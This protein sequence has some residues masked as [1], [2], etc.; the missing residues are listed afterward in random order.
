VC[1]SLLDPELSFEEAKRRHLAYINTPAKPIVTESATKS[2]LNLCDEYPCVVPFIP[3]PQVIEKLIM[4]AVQLS[5]DDEILYSINP[6]EKKRVLNELDLDEPICDEI[7]DLR[8]FPAKILYPS[9][10]DN[11]NFFEEVGLAHLAA[12]FAK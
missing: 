4:R 8:I 7:N 6:K 9:M 1:P 5:T 11:P 3:S 12:K 2:K 10:E